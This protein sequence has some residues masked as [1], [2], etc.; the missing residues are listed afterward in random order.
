MN[1]RSGPHSENAVSQDL[2]YVGGEHATSIGLGSLAAKVAGHHCGCAVG[3]TWFRKAVTRMRLKSMAISGVL[4]CLLAIAPMTYAA[5]GIGTCDLP[6]D[7]LQEITTKYPWA[8]IVT[9]PDLADDDKMLFRKDHGND[10]P[11]LVKADFYGDG[12]PTLALVLIVNA[13]GKES[14]ELVVAHEIGQKWAT[15]L[16]GNAGSSRPVIWSQSPGEYEEF[17]SEDL[18]PR[19]KVSVCSRHMI[20]VSTIAKSWEV[21]RSQWVDATLT[22]SL[23]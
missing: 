19:L 15:V 21:R 17:N 10:C 8:R 23:H 4:F 1:D 18:A 2:G 3:M 22:C 5:Q 9:F 11:G 16:L 13:G 14:A 20:S 12:K 7:L 6:K